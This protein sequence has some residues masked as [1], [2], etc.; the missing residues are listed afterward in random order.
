MKKI[1]NRKKSGNWTS[2]PIK[3]Y[4]IISSL[5][6]L[7]IMISLTILNADQTITTPSGSQINFLTSIKP[8]ILEN[9]NYK[10]VL[11]D[12]DSL[13]VKYNDKFTSAYL[14]LKSSFSGTPT[15][16]FDKTGKLIEADFKTGQEGNYVLGN[17]QVFLPAEAEVHFKEKKV[18][19]KL[20]SEKINLA[21]LPLSIDKNPGESVFEF[22]SL[23]KKFDFGNGNIFQG[24]S[25]KFEKGN[26]FFDFKGNAK[27]NSLNIINEGRTYI[28]FKGE[29]NKNYDS[30]YISIDDKKG[31]FVTGS[32]INERGPKISF[33]NNNPYG[34]KISE[35]DH[36][37]VWS[38]GNSKGS[39]VRI[40][41][42]NNEGRV[43]LMETLNQFA[44][45]FDEKST[46]YSYNQEKLFFSPKIILTGFQTGKTTSPIEIHNFRGSFD[47]FQPISNSD[48]KPNILGITP[49]ASWAYG[50]NPEFIKTNVPYE[51]YSSL[52]TGFSN[53]WLYYN[54]KSAADLQRLT[55]VRIND[56]TGLLNNAGYRKMFADI[57]LGLPAPVLK[58]LRELDSG[59]SIIGHAWYAGL[60][61]DDFINI[62]SSYFDPETIRHEISHQRH[63]ALDSGFDRL[64]S[65]VSSK[66][67]YVT[68]YA[69]TNNY[70]DIAETASYVYQPSFW[71]SKL[72]TDPYAPVYRGKLAVLAHPK[73]QVIAR[74]EFESLGLDYNKINDYITEAQKFTRR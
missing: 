66:G 57:M 53:S 52:K 42:R 44:I 51:K 63:F 29:I 74:E 33:T 32:N 5:F 72:T 68:S 49:E 10:Y 61:G 22:L 50:I 23:N 69:R 28:D 31:V 26:L 21:K 67:G 45:N 39:Y 38:L 59:I 2:I 55:G 14:N 12:G 1:N 46:H 11:K 36:F 27:L 6:L 4:L 60:S 25:I 73:Y 15:L 24:T 9:G 40:V 30:S 17:E 20:S 48:G 16:I 37:A 58:D 13:S 34:L 65:S 71:S 47:N 43:P 18:Q 64:W 19:I 54:I 7:I 8:E 35:K 62:K 56:R 3:N 41:N 70:E